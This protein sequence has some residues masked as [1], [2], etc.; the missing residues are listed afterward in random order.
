MN[1]MKRIQ[2]KYQKPLAEILLEQYQMLGSIDA[3]AEL[4]G[5]SKSAITYHA[6]REGLE[7]K[8]VL[9]RRGQE[10]GNG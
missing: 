2:E 10:V 1:K 8:T 5:V 7:F 9:V 3:L 4:L 6:A